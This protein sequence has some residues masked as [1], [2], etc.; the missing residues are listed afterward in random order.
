MKLLHWRSSER[1]SKRE[2]ES[3]RAREKE[4]VRE[5]GRKRER[6][7]ERK[8]ERE[9]ERSK[10]KQL[11]VFLNP[12]PSNFSDMFLEIIRSQVSQNQIGNNGR[13]I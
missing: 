3:E 7:Q 9:R 2:R 10:H 8:R 12:L 11:L 4:R 5:Q 6:E 13:W 1:A